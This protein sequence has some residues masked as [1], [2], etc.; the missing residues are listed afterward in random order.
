MQHTNLNLIIINEP[1]WVVSLKSNVLD[2]S[3]DNLVMTKYEFLML[4]IVFFLSTDQNKTFI[5]PKNKPLTLR[6][7]NL[8][9]VVVIHYCAWYVFLC[10]RRYIGQSKIKNLFCLMNLKEI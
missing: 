8:R 1:K 4:N 9:C 7:K 5:A 10:N 3:S 2:I 6:Q